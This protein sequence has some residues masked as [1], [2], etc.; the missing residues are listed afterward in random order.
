VAERI[1][2]ISKKVIFRRDK[3]D[4]LFAEQGIDRT[5]YNKSIYKIIKSIQAGNGVPESFYRKTT[6]IDYLY[7]KFQW[8][9]LHLDDD[10]LLIVKEMKDHVIFIIITDHTIFQDKPNFPSLSGVDNSVKSIEISHKM[11]AR[12][13]IEYNMRV[14]IETTK[15]LGNSIIE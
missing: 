15:L 14:V 8:I 9:H 1:R 7:K 3:N 10:V 12:E 2:H 11:K 5:K 13:G 6:G 4:K